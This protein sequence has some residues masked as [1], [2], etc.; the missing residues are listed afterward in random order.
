MAGAGA[1][2]ISVLPWV[3]AVYGVVLV[4]TGSKICEPLRRLGKRLHP[5]LGY[6]LGCPMCMGVWIGVLAALSGLPLLTRWDDGAFG[7]LAWLIANGA[8][9]SA[10]SWVLH[11]ALA[12]LGAEEL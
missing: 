11:V 7:I 10:A 6:L 9:G 4:V 5:T 1:S 2:Q 12:A 3:L 8:A